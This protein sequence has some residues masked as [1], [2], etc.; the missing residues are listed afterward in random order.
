LARGAEVQI[1]RELEFL[2][3]WRWV[4]RALAIEKADKRKAQDL[5]EG[6]IVIG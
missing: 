2:Y 6:G 4:T 1:Y 3:G 5:R